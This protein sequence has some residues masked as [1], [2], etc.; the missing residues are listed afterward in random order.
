M[1]NRNLHAS[2]TQ[3]RELESTNDAFWREGFKIAF[4]FTPFFGLEGGGE[5]EH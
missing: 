3:R 1:C 5:R 4:K 2:Q